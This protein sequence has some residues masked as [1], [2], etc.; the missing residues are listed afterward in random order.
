MLKAVAAKRIATSLVYISLTMR[1]NQ[2]LFCLVY[3]WGLW[4]L[5][6]TIRL[7][8]ARLALTR[9]RFSTLWPY[10]LDALAAHLLP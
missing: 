10:G 5:K 9:H 7:A 1:L 3:R 4:A 2:N 8:R 6:S